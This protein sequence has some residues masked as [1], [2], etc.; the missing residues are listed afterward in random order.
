[1]IGMGLLF[2]CG[3]CSLREMAMNQVGDILAE[4]GATFTSDEDPE[5]VADALP[6]GLKLM[7]SVLAEQPEHIGLLLAT[8]EGFTQYA[9]AFVYLEAVKM[10]SVDYYRARE[11]ELRSKKLFLRARDYGMRGLE[12][13]FPGFGPSFKANPRAAVRQV[14]IGW[15]R[16]ALLDCGFLGQRG[17]C[18]QDGRLPLGRSAQNRRVGGSGSRIG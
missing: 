8:S 12:A 18:G 1:M 15:G 7:E 10:R 4:T 16:I 14:D 9:Y 17:K 11:L 2:L 5:L 6:F 3:G 13:K